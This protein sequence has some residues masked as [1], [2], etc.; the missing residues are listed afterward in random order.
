MKKL[1]YLLIAAFLVFFV[2]QA[3]FVSDDSLMWTLEEEDCW[4]DEYYSEEDKYCYLIETGDIEYDDS[5]NFLEGLTNFFVWEWDTENRPL[6]SYDINEDEI[7]YPEPMNGGE[8]L[9]NREKDIATLWNTFKLLIPT[10]EIADIEKFV[11]YNDQDTLG[12]VNVIEGTNKWELGLSLALINPRNEDELKA[13]IVHEFAHVLSLREDQVNSDTD[14][15]KT[16]TLEEWCALI[17]SY[18]HRFYKSYWLDSNIESEYSELVGTNHDGTEDE[19][20]VGEFY[21][22]NQDAFVS[23]YAATNITEDIAESFMMFVLQGSY[24][25][26]IDLEK[27]NLSDWKI[28]FFYDFPELVRLRKFMR[29]SL[30]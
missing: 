16:L 15:C 17:G 21:D 27:N 2:Y 5:S 19:N 9:Q 29:K 13:T 12:Y 3:F 11:V 23:E 25:E 26:E 18:I 28:M 1:I 6:V 30:N 7:A 4:E 8:N 14:N 10:S 22:N 24:D 20:N